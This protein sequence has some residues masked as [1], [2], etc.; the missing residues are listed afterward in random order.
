MSVKGGEVRDSIPISLVSHTVFCERRA[1]LEAVGERSH[2]AQMQAGSRAHRRVDDP[3]ASRPEAHRSM[4]LSSE[5]YGLL[6]RADLVE[7]DVDGTHVVEYKATPV[8][9]RAEV[10]EA[11]IV[12]LALQGICLEEAGKEVVG[13]SVYFTDQ[14]RCVDVEI[15][16]EERTRALKFLE[17]TRKICSDAQAPPPLEDDARCRRCSHIGVCLPDERSLSTI[18]RR[19]VVANP[20]GQVLHLTTP[21]SRASIRRGRVVVKAADEE[22]GNVPI[23][24]VQG[25]TVHGNVDISSA[26]L[27]ELFWRDITV[28]WCSGAGRV[29]GW[30]RPAD[31]PNGAARVQQHVASADGRIDIAR[32]FIAGKIAGQ[33]TFLRRNGGEAA[34]D[35]S[36]RLRSLQREAE[37]CTSTGA[38]FGV[39]GEAAALYFQGFPLMLRG[40]GAEYFLAKWQGRHGRGALDPLNSA[41]NFAYALLTAEAIKALVSCGLD[42]HAGFLHSS[43]RNKPALALDLMEEFRAS[44]SDSVVVSCVNRGMLTEKHFSTVSGTPRLKPEG[45]KVLVTAFERRMS[46]QITHPTFGY[47]ATW[48]RVLEIQA[49]LVLG[50]IDGT[51][52]NYRAVRTR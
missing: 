27:R 43:G 30:S 34:S 42:P 46:T 10:S 15:G 31:G 2:S 29:Y 6:G 45:R 14:H 32:E 4:T 35:L 19:V 1:W 33:A 9:N 38:L 51:Q 50:C 17:R 7:G 39:E 28:V 52:R 49:R 26:L 47:I 44:I 36:S 40:N 23:E 11:T 20:D 41:L 37:R 21:G 13:Y 22:L 12:Q 25:V 16:E 48:R 3:R 18:H 5:R 24:R 8:R